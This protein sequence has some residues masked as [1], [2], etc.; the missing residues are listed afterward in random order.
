MVKNWKIALSHHPPC[1][2]FSNHTFKIFKVDFCIGCFIGI[3]FTVI[4]LIL[5]NL[6]IG[7]LDFSA[8]YLLIIGCVLVL[9]Q[10]LSLTKLTE[11]KIIKMIQKFSIGIGAGVILISTYHLIQAPQYLRVLIVIAILFIGNLPIQY[12]HVKKSKQVCNDCIDKWNKE[13][14]PVDY[15]YADIPKKLKNDKKV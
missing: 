8:Q 5:G 12:L 10:L 3:P 2:K 11:N 7:T 15:C 6:F 13:I 1:E 4:G 9:A 14:C